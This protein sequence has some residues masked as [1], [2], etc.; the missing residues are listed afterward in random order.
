MRRRRLPPTAVSPTW[1]GGKLA[2]MDW[3]LEKRTARDDF[4]CELSAHAWAGVYDVVD[5]VGGR[6]RR[7]GRL[8]G[9]GAF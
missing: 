1:T 2:F 8:G 7:P 6:A 4:A 9:Q 3:A 5:F